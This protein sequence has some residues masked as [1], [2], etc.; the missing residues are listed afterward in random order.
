MTGDDFEGRLSGWLGTQLPDAKDVRMEGLD[1]VEF[2]HSAEM[3]VLTIVSGTG[4]TEER[5]DVVLRL[6]PQP[7]GVARTL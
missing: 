6:R 7:P 3:M 2:G 5:R 1:R 4:G